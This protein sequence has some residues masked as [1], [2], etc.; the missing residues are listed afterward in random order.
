MRSYLLTVT[1]IVVPIMIGC[2]DNESS[3]AI[4]DASSLG[5][6]SLSSSYNPDYESCSAAIVNYDQALNEQQKQI[7]QAHNIINYTFEYT[8]KWGNSYYG[9]MFYWSGATYRTRVIDS[10][11]IEQINLDTNESD[12]AS[13]SLETLFA[14][15][16]GNRTYDDVFGYVNHFYSDSPCREIRVS[17]LEPIDEANITTR[18]RML[19]TYQK[20]RSMTDDKSCNTTS[21]CK[22]LPF[23]NYNISGCGDILVYSE[24]QTDITML[25]PLINNYNGYIQELGL[26]AAACAD[27]ASYELQ[28]NVNLQQC[29]VTNYSSAQAYS[30]EAATF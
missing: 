21:Q 4:P 11:A 18:E 1:M 30:S 12:S 22:S 2:S 16:S 3:N 29:E 23:K 20:I 24:K 17:A 27:A 25:Q 9:E 15:V 14:Y 26:D 8:E 13:F 10:E 7:W 19:S 5:S 6:S 28:C